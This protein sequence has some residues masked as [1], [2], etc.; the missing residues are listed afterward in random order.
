MRVVAL[1]DVNAMFASCA[2]A[3]DPSLLGKPVLVAGDPADRRSIV[4]TAS[5][6]ARAFGVTTAMPV[7]AAL[8]L[9]PQA[10]LVAPDHDLYRRYSQRLFSVLQEFTPVVAPVSID[11]AYLDLTGCPGLEDGPEP[12]AH[13]IRHTVREKTGLTVSLGISDGRWPAKMAACL[14]KR[15]PTGVLHLGPGDLHRLIWPLPIRAFHG[16]GPRT[17]ERLEAL[18]IRTIGALAGADDTR[19]RTLGRQGRALRLLAQGVDPSPVA[20]ESAVKSISHELTFAHDLERPDDIRP[21]LLGLCDQVAHRLRREGYEAVSV[22]LRVR[23]REF[24][25][26]SRQLTLA[27]PAQRTDLLHRATQTLLG[28]FPAAAFPAR[29]VG[30]AAGRL[31]PAASTSQTLFPDADDLR[32]ERLAD[33]VVMLKEKFGEDAVLPLGTV[34]SAAHPSYDRRRHGSSFGRHRAPG[35]GS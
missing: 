24:V 15:E 29:L 32:R 30:V 26:F 27:A 16:V 28:R 35:N 31:A 13:R 22:T 19:L 14:A 34:R 18:S 5:Y 25:D 8:R 12:L 9:C 17:A 3:E 7:R 11:E 23:N 4:L 20:E 1:C 21:V 33:A 2:V 6:E 10:L